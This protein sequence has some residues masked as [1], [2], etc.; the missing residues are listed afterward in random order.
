VAP[1][2]LQK[3]LG[4]KDIKTT[5]QYVALADGAQREASRIAEGYRGT[6]GIMDRIA[7][8]PQRRSTRDEDRRC[9]GVYPVGKTRYE[10]RITL[11]VC[12]KQPFD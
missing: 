8:A 10:A 7:I 6:E 4:H 5:L 1:L 3:W 2:T 12:K 9:V 11:N